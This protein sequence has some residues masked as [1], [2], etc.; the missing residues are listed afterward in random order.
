MVSKEVIAH[1]ECSVCRVAVREYR[2]MTVAYNTEDDL[3]E[4]TARYICDP[5]KYEGVW[6]TKLDIQRFIKIPKSGKQLKI[7]LE[8]KEGECNRECNAVETACGSSLE[9]STASLVSFML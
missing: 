8:E 5:Y 4:E 1:I 3:L 2:R 6:V 9:N 7:E